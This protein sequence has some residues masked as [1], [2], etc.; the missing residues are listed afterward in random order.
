MGALYREGNRKL[1]AENNFSQGL[2]TNDPFGVGRNQSTAESGWDTHEH[3]YLSTAKGRT[4]YGTSGA[5]V[6][7]LLANFNNTHLVRAV[8]T[9]LQYNSS[10]STWAAIAGTFTNTP[11][12]AT[13]FEVSGA[14]VLV[15][16]NGTD[17]P[18]YWNG[19]ALSTLGGTPPVGK[20][21]TTDNVRL[22]IAKDDII[23]F[24][25]YLDGQDWSSAEDSGFIQYYTI[26]GGNITALRNFYGDKYV[27]KKDGMAVIQ[28]SNYFNFALKE[29]SNDIGCVNARTI[30]EVG[31]TL[32]WLG[33][34]DVYAFKGGLPSPIGEPIRAYLADLNTALIT[35]CSS[36]TDGLRYY[37]CLVTGAATE[38]NVRLCYDPRYGIWRVT[39]E[40]E[41]YRY[42]V[43]LNN[44]TY[45]GNA[46]GQ[47][48]SINT[49]ETPADHAWT[50][51]GAAFDEGMPEAEKTYSELHVQ[52]YFPEGTTLTVGVSSK[53]SGDD[54]TELDYDPL[55]NS[56]HAQ[57]KN[58]IIPLDQMDLCH[59]FRYRLSGTGPARIYNVQRYY[60]LHRV[61]R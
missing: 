40:D 12:D 35:K 14:S 37:L 53:E 33:E 51:T 39:G 17:N 61:Q 50:V 43:R 41:S 30:Q 29:I 49:A 11:W 25:A 57:N 58:L 54:F 13:N 26:N 22:W 24:S 59:W 28:G 15:L 47:T 52:G 23:H 48:Y 60:R 10:G 16:V 7:N 18:R 32:F 4:T 5:A 42:S 21:I 27:W 19:S 8:G 3:P 46:S 1:R 9:A 44:V 2:N 31:D 6:T 38:P 55:E 45:A 36:M 20:Y 34:N 56:G